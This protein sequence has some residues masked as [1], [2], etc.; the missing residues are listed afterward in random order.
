MRLQILAAGAMRSSS[1]PSHRLPTRQEPRGRRPQKALVALVLAWTAG[2]V[3]AVG[4]ILL[5]GVFT[6]HLSG[7]SAAMAV[8]AGSHNWIEFLARGVPIPVFVIAVFVGGVLLET[9]AR[10]GVRRRLGLLIAVELALLLAFFLA[11]LAQPGALIRS[12]RPLYFVLIS[13]LAA[14][15]GLQT[16]AL[17]RV[18]GRT[19]RTTYVTGMLTNFANEMVTWTLRSWR[20]PASGSAREARLA[21]RRAAFLI[22][23]WM[24]FAAGALLGG[25]GEPLWKQW[26]LLP[27][28][29]GLCVV[30]GVEAA[31]PLYG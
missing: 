22:E 5:A 18:G 27:A 25:F 10:V 12:W 4:Y 23:L 2:V 20:L 21:L 29:G 31:R 24:A 17:Q 30:L 8:H 3:D 26:A 28:I 16:S 6:A 1:P 9:A 11:A 15:M 19:I 7:D 13:V 14:A